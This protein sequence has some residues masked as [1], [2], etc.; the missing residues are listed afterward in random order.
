M[1]SIFES[2]Y[3]NNYQ[4][5]DYTEIFVLLTV[6]LDASNGLSKHQCIKSISNEKNAYFSFVFQLQF[7]LYFKNSICYLPFADCS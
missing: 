2:Y 1:L 4:I 5:S 6:L 3:L 7:V